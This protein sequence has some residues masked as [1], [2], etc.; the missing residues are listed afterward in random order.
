MASITVGGGPSNWREAF[1]AHPGLAVT[2][3]NYESLLAL[4]AAP[5]PEPAPEAEAAPVPKP[6]K[7]SLT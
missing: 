6:K 2:P 3:G 1:L 4:A 5:G 7:V